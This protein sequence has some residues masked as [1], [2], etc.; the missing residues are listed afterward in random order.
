V[1]SGPRHVGAA[2]QLEQE[3]ELLGEELVVVVEVLAEQRE[4]LDERAASG[5]DLGTTAGQEVDGGE[6]LE[7]A[8]RVGRA[9]DGDRARQPDALRADGGGGEC[10][11]R[12]GDGEVRAVVL[13][14]TEDLEAHLVRELNLLHEVTHALLGADG[15]ADVGEGGETEFHVAQPSATR[16]ARN[17]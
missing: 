5:H 8:D 10:D 14:H 7:D 11:R 13:A 16:C 4:G 9:Q 2:A 17:Y 12:R 15:G 6:V 3:A 1:T